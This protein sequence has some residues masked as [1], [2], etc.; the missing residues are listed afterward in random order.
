VKIGPLNGNP[1]VFDDTI[2]FLSCWSEAEAEFIE[3]LL[4]S[5]IAHEF[6]QSMIHWDEKRP[7]TVEILKRL[8]IRRLA[9]VL[10]HEED[11]VRFTESQELP[12][13]AAL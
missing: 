5:R 9:A 8:S 11:Y 12:L 4:N 10:G 6:L 7:V 1:V 13:F 2:Y 3:S